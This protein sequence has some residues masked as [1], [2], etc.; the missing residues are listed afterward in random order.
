M[1]DDP[2]LA[3]T[4]DSASAAA[5]PSITDDDEPTEAYWMLVAAGK[6]WAEA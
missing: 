3:L 5:P 1:S 6:I 2:D 4:I